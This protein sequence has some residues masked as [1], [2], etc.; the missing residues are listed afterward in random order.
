[1][2]RFLS[3]LTVAIC[4]CAVFT[5]AP[6]FAQSSSIAGVVTDA[7]GAVLPGVTVEAT[8][9]ALIEGSRTVVSDN[10]GRYAVVELRPGTFAITFTL[11]GFSTVKREGIELSAGF[12]ANVNATLRVGS[13]EETITV[14]GA[15]PVVDVQNVVKQSLISKEVI[16][17]IPT[18]KSW[19][20]LGMLTVGVTSSTAD[21]GGSAGEQQNAMAAHGG[22]Q[23]DKVIEQDGMRLGLLLGDTSSTGVSSNDASTQEVTVE[24]GASSA[25]STGGGVRINIIP[26]EGGNQFSGSL[27]SNF[28][29]KA[30]SNS[31]FSDDLKATGVKAPDRV[32]R[33]YDSSFALGGP[34]KKDKLWFFTAQRFW[35]YQN[36]RADAFYEANPFD[37]K[38]DPDTS[39]QAYDDQT[40]R[41]HNLRLT[42]QLTPKNKIAVFYDYQP[43]CTCHW[44]VSATRP[45]EASPVQ[46]LPL[47]WY[48]TVSYTS[49]ITTRLMF[50]AGFSNLSTDWT[51]LPQDDGVPIDPSTGRLTSEGYGVQDTATG[52]TYRAYGAPFNYNFSATR[53]W[54]ATLN[55]VTGSHQMKFGAALLDGERSVRNWM[56]SSDT[57][58]IFNNGTPIGIRRY[59][60]PYEEKEN[61]EADLGIFAQDTWRVQHFTFNIGVRFDYM[62]QSVPAQVAPAG[63]W[64]GERQWAAIK[65][66]PSWKDLEPRFGMVYDL[67]GTGRTALKATLNRYVAQS[68]TAF[69]G[70]NNPITTSINSSTQNWTDSNGD[71]VPQANELSG[72]QSPG[73]VGSP[74]ATT[75]YDDAVRSGWGVRRNN[76]EWSLG[77]QHELL[78]RVG[79]DVSYFHRGQGNFTATDNRAVTPSDFQQFCVTA[80]TD[81]RLPMSGQPICGLYDVVP[82][83]AGKVDN[84]VTFNDSS[85]ERTEVWQGLDLNMNARLGDK[86]FAQGGL[87]TG[88]TEFSNCL[89]I[90]NPGQFV[91][92]FINNAGSVNSTATQYC[93]WTTP[94]QTQYKAMAGYTF[95]LAIQTSVA[96][97]SIP[98]R[99]IQ[100]TWAATNAF[101]APS[102]GRNL[103][104]STTYN[105]A[106]IE[107]GTMYGDRINQVDLR[108][109][110][111]VSLGGKK[112]LRVMADVYNAMNVSPVVALNTTYNANQAANNW[113]RPTQILVGRFL[114]V[115][116]Q[117]DF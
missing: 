65:D 19:S 6:A 87:S 10:N 25:E 43:R 60:T 115:G 77:V 70:L 30:M 92:G 98:G 33:I 106:L 73:P 86:M 66:V 110:K 3:G 36:L 117:L 82:S 105:V 38:Y 97:Q 72:A 20:Q 55:Y 12:A 35:G 113:G 75:V 96:F 31:N 49:T 93:A 48:G 91:N 111:N 76:W 109:S 63:T 94:F 53:N 69:A 62:N 46:D 80:P 58:L 45:A 23:G 56:T 81:S 88:R 67:F 9:P 47:N 22:A 112:K 79:L 52:I 1:M 17:V 89:A 107:P 14:S 50:T 24:V 78:P 84:V 108:F 26:K 18:G 34:I 100:A 28:A 114:K 39:R 15:T 21:V 27:F 44:T 102:L 64:V 29:N 71:L 42:S 40:L 95:P 61:L 37:Y 104:G 116:A 41:S 16:D 103:A 57:Q 4:L 85:K 32:N 51:R 101:I 13:L 74:V 54:R 59:S 83:K 99:E 68:A 11:P 7:T 2:R 90:D 8:S 5:S